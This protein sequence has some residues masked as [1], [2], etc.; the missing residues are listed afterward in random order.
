MFDEFDFGFKF[1]LK[2]KACSTITESLLYTKACLNTL[3]II[4]NQTS[5][6]FFVK[7]R[8]CPYYKLQSVY[9]ILLIIEDAHVLKNVNY[10]LKK[11][12]EFRENVSLTY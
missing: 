9:T 12:I 2:F 3:M 10:F 8:N 11:L 4:L 6:P 5:S 7:G 1:F